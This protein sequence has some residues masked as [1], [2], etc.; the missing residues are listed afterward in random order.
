MEIVKL[1]PAFK[2]YLWG[3]EKLRTVYH[4]QS[5]LQRLAESWELSAHPDGQC[6][7][8]SGPDTGLTLS[9]YLKKYGAS[10]MGANAAAFPFFPVLIKFIDAKLPLSVQVHPSDAYALKHEN[11]F[12]KTEMWY[13]L[14][15]TP[16]AFLYCG[17]NRSVCPE[18][19]KQRIHDGTLTEVLNRCPVQ[20][21]DVFFIEAGTIHA[22]GAG[23]TICE[24]QQNSNCTYRI[25]DYN[26]R[27]DEGRL[28]PL[29]VEKALQVMTLTEMQDT[30]RQNRPVSI[31]GGTITELA[32]CS[33]FHAV[34]YES[35]SM[36][37]LSTAS[38]F[39]SL[40]MLDGSAELRGPENHIRCKK[41]ES[42]FIPANTPDIV[43]S[44]V[45]E[46]IWTTV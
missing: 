45:C 12:G 31:P 21:G 24:I 33:Y 8:E 18:E 35:S 40:V 19:F 4:K 5:D 26:R 3:G 32:A 25:Y 43:L 16:G 42:F 37:R 28:R 2:D 30:V 44:G 46:F 7:I 10:A 14:D 39:A 34:K 27:D 15:C 23:I 9:A 41:G 22:I 29:H 17:V 38:S 1:R 11:Q 36:V 13:V 6:L 20:P